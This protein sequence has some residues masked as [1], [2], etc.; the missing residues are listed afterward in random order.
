[1]EFVAIRKVLKLLKILTI[2]T[3]SLIHRLIN[4]QHAINNFSYVI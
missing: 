2:N 4:L 1:M 3:K